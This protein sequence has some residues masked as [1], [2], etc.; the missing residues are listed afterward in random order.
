MWV[1]G[2]IKQHGAGIFAKNVGIADS[3]HSVL[4]VDLWDV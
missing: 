2:S 3:G 1:N 4:S